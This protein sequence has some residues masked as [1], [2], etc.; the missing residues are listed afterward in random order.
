MP[1][2]KTA[3]EQANPET[4]PI[5]DSAEM[6]TEILEANATEESTPKLLKEKGV[7]LEGQELLALIKEN[8]DEP[9]DDVIYKAGYF[10]RT[11]NTETGESKIT[12]HKN[13]FFEAMSMASNPDLK[14]APAKR[15]YA[16]RQGRKPVVTV[17][18]NGNIVVG[19]RH[20]MVAGFAPGSK[21]KVEAE[22]GRIVLTA[23]LSEEGPEEVDSDV[24]TEGDDTDLDL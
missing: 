16:P 12:I 19:G 18:R 9:V 22:A 8:K 21:V 11:I 7:R 4:N 2:R 20:S 24:E 13:P 6:S 14:L 3:T 10:T 15:A 23:Y 17:V 1:R 5:I